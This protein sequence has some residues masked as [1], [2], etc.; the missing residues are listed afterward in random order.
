M[1]AGGGGTTD[2]V[3]DGDIMSS[4]MGALAFLCINV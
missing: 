2:V 4:G 1:A 3:F